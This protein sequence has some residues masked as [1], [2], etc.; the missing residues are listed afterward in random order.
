MRLPPRVTKI[1]PPSGDFLYGRE[2]NCFSS[3]HLEYFKPHCCRDKRE[4]AMAEVKVL[5]SGFA[6]RTNR[7]Y[8]GFCTVPLIWG[9]KDLIFDTGQR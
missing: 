2:K 1:L 9:E 4:I 3:G 8:L 7:A 5:L 6:L